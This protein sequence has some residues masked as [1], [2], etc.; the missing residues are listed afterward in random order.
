LGKNKW[1]LVGHRD[2]MKWS[3]DGMKEVRSRIDN[4][5]LGESAKNQMGCVDE[6]L[7]TS[8]E[9]EQCIS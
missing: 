7:F 5:E 8:I 2:R 3:L 4:G 6:P 9:V 1:D